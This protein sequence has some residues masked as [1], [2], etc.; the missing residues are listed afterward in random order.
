MQRLGDAQTTVNAP[1]YH[2]LVGLVEPSVLLNEATVRKLM[3][4]QPVRSGHQYWLHFP[5]AQAL[6]SLV[7]SRG[8]AARIEE[9]PVERFALGMDWLAAVLRN[10]QQ[11]QV[12][13]VVAVDDVPLL[14]CTFLAA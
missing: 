3:R 2:Q 10:M 12:A 9:R 6:W 7:E 13:V 11:W 1:D 5:C 8:E 14:V 4:R